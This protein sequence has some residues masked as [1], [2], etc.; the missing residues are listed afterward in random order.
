MSDGPHRSLPM[1]PKWKRVAESAD[2]PAFEAAE[3]RNALIPALEEDFRKEVSEEFL[4]GLHHVCSEHETLLFKNHAL[5]MLESLRDEA[6]SGMGRVVLEY[7]LQAAT[8]G[9]IGADIAN[10]A[11]ERA[12]TDRAARCSRQ[13]EEHY[14]RE[15]TEPRANRVRGRI[16]QAIGNADIRGMAQRVSASRKTPATI[17]KRSGLEDGV[18][19]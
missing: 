17:A 6:G 5:P 2:N 3:V 16:E 19:L 1:R 18:K 13:V 14:C 15:S 7:A 12:L 9:N 10:K 8:I 11:I 4:H